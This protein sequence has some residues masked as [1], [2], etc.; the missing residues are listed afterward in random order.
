MDAKQQIDSSAATT[1]IQNIVGE[2]V[3]LGPLRKDLMPAFTRW[4]NDFGTQRMLRGIARPL[5]LEQEENWYDRV[6]SLSETDIMF[7]MYERTTERPIGTT[8]LYDIDYR[9]RTAEFGI[10]IAEPNARGKGYGTEA[11]QLLL[12]YAFTALG[13]HNVMLHVFPHNPAAI[14]AYT[15]AGFKE[16]GRRRESHL[17][18][19]KFWDEIHME[20]LSTEWEPSPILAEVFQSDGPCPLS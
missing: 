19:G 1:P 9:D 13:L 7:T 6:M 15:K 5:T 2:K 20:C 4:L 18:G 12:G 11:T 16:F 17:M 10:T 3:A 8:G 14:C